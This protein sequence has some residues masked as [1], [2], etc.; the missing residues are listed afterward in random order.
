MSTC[1][2]V[3]DYGVRKQLVADRG[4]GEPLEASP[5]ALK[6]PEGTFTL[7]VYDR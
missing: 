4:I 3:A 7:R 5:A 2:L 6:P 1:G